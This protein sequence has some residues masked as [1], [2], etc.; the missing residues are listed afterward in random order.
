[1][2]H[3]KCC[4]FYR[5]SYKYKTLKIILNKQENEIYRYLQ[6]GYLRE[7]N[8]FLL[9]ISIE[10]SIYFLF[11]TIFFSFFPLH[12]I[13]LVYVFACFCTVEN[14]FHCLLLLIT[15]LAEF[16]LVWFILVAIAWVV[17]PTRLLSNSST[18]ISVEIKF[19]WKLLFFLQVIFL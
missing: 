9:E 18:Q 13:L 5:L 14:Q 19:S 16:S 2:Y 15:N 1:M 7:W 11:R 17:I 10:N 8:H 12:L 4:N 6:S 3:R